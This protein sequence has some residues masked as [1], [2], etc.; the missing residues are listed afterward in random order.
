MAILQTHFGVYGVVIRESRILV[1]RKARGPYTGLLDLPGG[2][3]E[4]GESR[5]ETLIRELREETGGIAT[6]FGPW[7]QFSIQVD[8]DSL[9]QPIE[10]HHVGVWR[11]VALNEIQ[12]ERAA[13]EDVAGLEW[14]DVSNWNC[15][16][17]LSAALRCVL[18]QLPGAARDLAPSQ[19]E[20]A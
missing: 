18:S 1:V 13:F 20:R 11:T 8:R 16:D 6:E 4:P 10:F 14:M 2:S 15:R 5:Q 3:P 17:D 19:G 7:N 12:F 9:G